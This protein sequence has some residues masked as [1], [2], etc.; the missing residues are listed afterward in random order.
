M[1][2][3]FTI[4][5]KLFLGFVAYSNTA[6]FSTGASVT[7]APK[8]CHFQHRTSGTLALVLGLGFHVTTLVKNRTQALAWEHKLEVSIS[9]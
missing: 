3:I 5:F 6:L 1:D 2:D 4:G 9:C 7:L 8:S